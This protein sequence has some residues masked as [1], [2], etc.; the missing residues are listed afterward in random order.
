M[1]S[2]FF[3]FFNDGDIHEDGHTYTY[4]FCLW[5]ETVSSQFVF[6]YSLYSDYVL[7]IGVQLIFVERTN[8]GQNNVFMLFKKQKAK[9]MW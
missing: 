6:P 3:F 7:H 8:S 5:S 2:L 9:R 1:I 4:I